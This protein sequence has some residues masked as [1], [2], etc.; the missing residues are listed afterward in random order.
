MRKGIDIS[1]GSG[2]VDFHALKQSG[3][4]FVICRAGWGSSASQKDARLDDYVRLAH[5]AG[6]HI[7]AYWFIYAR[8]IPEAQKNGMCFAEVCEKY[9][10][11][12]DMPLY[13]DYEN[14]STRYYQQETKQAETRD[15]ATGAIVAAV[16]ELESRGWYSGYYVNLDYYKNRINADYLKDFALWLALWRDSGSSPEVNCGIWQYSGDTKIAE[17]SGGVDLNFSYVDYPEVIRRVGLNGF[18]AEAPGEVLCEPKRIMGVPIV[19]NDDFTWQ[20]YNG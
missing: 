13:I 6:L 5:D 20:Y 19:L 15:F 14:D 2:N 16:T 17:A 11:I 3:Y 4:D 9:K 18:K 12:L 10:G 7:G 1:Q 8:S